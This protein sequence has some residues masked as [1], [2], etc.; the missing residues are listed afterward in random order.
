MT[1]AQLLHGFFNFLGTTQGEL[2]KTA[3][4]LIFYIIVTYMILSEW[5]RNRKRELK[6]LILAFASLV[7]SKIFSVYFLASFVFTNAPAHF[8]TLNTAENFVEIFALFLLANAFVYPILAQKKLS[9]RKFMADHLL[10][11]IGVSFVLSMFVLS[12]ID[13][14]GGSLQDFWTNTSISVAEVV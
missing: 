14:R 11:I 7:I 2:L 10:L 8:W 3:V 4:E 6:F 13:L 1:F 5:T 9:A 12:I